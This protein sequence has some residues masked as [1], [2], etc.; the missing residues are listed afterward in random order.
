[1]AEPRNAKARALAG[2]LSA[3]KRRHFKTLRRISRE[4]AIAACFSVLTKAIRI[5]ALHE[6]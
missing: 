4:I 3:G 5:T 2:G 6:L 1:L